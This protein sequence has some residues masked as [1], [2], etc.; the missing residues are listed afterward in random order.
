MLATTGDVSNFYIVSFE[1]LDKTG[2]DDDSGVELS[3][4]EDS[5]LIPT[6][7]VKFTIG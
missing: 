2:L 4:A 3:V 1:E 7:G 5:V 6:K